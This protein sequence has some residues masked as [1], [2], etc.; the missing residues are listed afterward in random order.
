MLG[1]VPTFFMIAAWVI[2]ALSIPEQSFARQLVR[3]QTPS[4]TT[5]DTAAHRIRITRVATHLEHPWSVAFLPSG[6]I[7]VT[8]RPGRLRIIRNGVLDPVPIAGVPEVHHHLD[9]GLLDL[10]L[11][12]EFARNRLVYF[13]YSRAGSQGATVALARG[14][15]D[16][17]ALHDVTDVFV[18]EAWSTTDVQYGSRIAFG[19]DGT[20]FMS[21]G[22]RNQRERAQLL[23]DHAGTIIRIRDDGSVPDDNPFVG[24]TDARPEIYSYG[25]RNVQGLAVHPDTGALWANEHGPQGGD[26]VNLVMAGKN[27]GWPRVSL[28]REYTGAPVSDA[29]DLPGMERPLLFWSPS[30][31]ISGMTFYTGRRLGGWTGDLF[32]GGLAGRSL[33]RIMLVDTASYGHE[34]LLGELHTRIRDVRQGPDELL[35]VVTDEDAGEI[36]RLEPDDDSGDVES[37]PDAPA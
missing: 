12:P 1:T 31:G 4:R 6:D 30:I 24:L 21:V 14:R 9:G 19:R 29:W 20:L 2:A 7:L 36:L 23:T 5:A 10:A 15:F 27:Y 26:E 8:E 13:T 11:H 22:E 16:G 18:A 25:H 35:Y 17:I 34:A 32:V 37:V 28:G 33:Q 3:E